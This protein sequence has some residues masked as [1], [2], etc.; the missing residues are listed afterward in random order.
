MKLSLETLKEK[1]FWLKR[2][3]K[4]PLFDIQKVTHNTKEHPTW[5]HFGAGN[6]FKTFLASAQQKLLNENLTDTGIIVCET[7]DEEIIEKTYR[8]FDNLSIAC[9]LKSSGAIQKDIIA[10]ITESLTKM[11]IKRLKEIMESETL[12]IVTFTVTEKGYLIKNTKGEF[13]EDTLYDFKNFVPEQKTLMGFISYMCY[14]RFRLGKYPVTLVSLDNYSHNGS[15]L[16]SAIKTFANAW[17]ENGFVESDFIDYIDDEELIYFTWSMIDKITPT[18]S[19]LVRDIL[20]NDGIENTD[21]IVTNKKSYT[22]I[23]ANAEELEYLAIEEK[24]TNSRP[25]LEKIGVLFSD[26][27]TIDKIE[28]MKV[29]TCLNPL[30]T[31]LAIF[32]HLLGYKLISDEM[33]DDDLLSLIKNI[34]YK[35]GLPVVVDPKI[36]NPKK[37]LDEVINIRL[38][39]PYMPDGPMRIAS[40]TSQKMPIRFGETIK[41]YESDKT[42]KASSLVYIPFVF[43]AWMRYLMGIDDNENPIT[44]SS[45]PRLDELCGYIKDIRLGDTSLGDKLKP[46]LSDASIFGV[47][48]YEVGLANKVE[49]YFLMLIK[50]RNAVRDTLHNH[51]LKL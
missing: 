46:I 43:A 32:G 6:I 18:P 19:E 30:H 28:K 15:V 48:L 9:T 50:G 40:D 49:A 14:I 51:I 16:Q 8:P 35:E 33:K 44:L 47:N 11:D 21:I 38:P 10:S 13:F 27:E 41:A 2:H 3:Y 1:D 39:N 22:S 26:R 23:F 25:P 37:F 42:K 36:I 29:C 4:L 12:Q 5:L 45:D 24:F 31:T 7:F 20:K 34:G 17:L